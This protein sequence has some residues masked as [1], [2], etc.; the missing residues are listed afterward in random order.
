MLHF[1]DDE[2]DLTCFARPF[3]LISQTCNSM[4]RSFHN[5]K[6]KNKTLLNNWNVFTDSG[7][8]PADVVAHIEE[9]WVRCKGHDLDAGLNYSPHRM[10][11]ANASALLKENRFLIEQST[12]HLEQLVDLMDA[13][14][15]VITLANH[16]CEVV[17]TLGKNLAMPEKVNLVPGSRWLEEDCGTNGIG[18]SV[19]EGKAL[20]IFGHE[21]YC[22]GWHEW[23]C[24]SSPIAD[25]FTDKMIG[26][27]NIS[28]RKD[29]VPLHNIALVR[30]IAKMIESSIYDH[31]QFSVASNYAKHFSSNNPVII[32]D[33]YFR[34][35]YVNL[36][37]VRSL[38]LLKGEHF[39]LFPGEVNLMHS[40]TITNKYKDFKGKTWNVTT[41]SFR[42]NNRVLGRIAVFEKVVS[43]PIESPKKQV[44][45]QI[46]FDHIITA[47][48]QIKH[49]KTQA[50][51]YAKTDLNVLITGE[52]GTGKELFARAIHNNSDRKDKP[53]VVINCGAI[54]RDL[55][56]SELFGYV[57][58]AFTNAKK[59]GQKGKFVAAD[60]GT[61]FLDEIGEL[62]L[63]L[64]PYL[65][66]VLEEGVVY[67][68]GAVEGQ[69]VDVRII[70]ATNRDLKADVEADKFRADLYYRLNI[71]KLAIPA[72]RERKEDIP[73][74]FTAFLKEQK[75]P[76]IQVRQEVFSA[77]Q[78]HDWQGNVRELRNCFHKIL[79]NFQLHNE[80]GIIGAKDLPE[81]YLA[82]KKIFIPI[83]EEVKE[84]PL[85]IEQA[86]KITKG[87]KSKAADLLGISRMTL[88]RKLGEIS[89]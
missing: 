40:I 5:Y 3:L 83:D 64:Q 8:M 11:D 13:D 44:I 49:L 88:Y 1:R 55:V 79:F 69:A 19:I 74:L 63:D 9:S 2:N 89:N 26:I 61:L 70:A 82:T 7:E 60:K 84:C 52:T 14:T 43:I 65:L 41:Q 45:E 58:G 38:H 78:Q 15:P 66:R 35:K 72:L 24:T 30:S 12:P 68:V 85:T 17:T 31:V 81:E 76:T 71:L 20:S 59:G 75:F 46:N 27:I 50:N 18:T 47:N 25:P 62:P 36:E 39:Q 29:F 22:Q 77:L 87:N 23:V 28:G 80:E 42:I 16:D 34:I 4:V 86:L 54:P 33:E 56:A 10:S 51:Q 53:F 21:H 32:F 6:A 37:A 57:E 73:A 67:P 48:P